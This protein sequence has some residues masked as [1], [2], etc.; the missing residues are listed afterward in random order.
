MA[1]KLYST[2]KDDNISLNHNNYKKLHSSET[3][4]ELLQQ[5][6][7]DLYAD[8]LVNRKT[9]GYEN[10]FN[11]DQLV[12]DLFVIQDE[13]GFDGDYQQHKETI[14]NNCRLLVSPDTT[15]RNFIS[16]NFRQKYIFNND[17]CGLNVLTHLIKNLETEQDYK[18]FIYFAIRDKRR[19]RLLFSQQENLNDLVKGFNPSWNLSQNQ[20][21]NFRTAFIKIMI[22][23]DKQIRNWIGK[24]NRKKIDWDRSSITQAFNIAN[25]EEKVIKTLNFFIRDNKRREKLINSGI[26][27]NALVAET[28]NP[29]ENNIKQVLFPP[30]PAIQV[31]LA[32]SKWQELYTNGFKL[33]SFSLLAN[34]LMNS[35]KSW[36]DNVWRDKE[37]TATLDNGETIRGAGADLALHAY[38]DDLLAAENANVA[39]LENPTVGEMFTCIDN[40]EQQIDQLTQENK[41]LA[42]QKNLSQTEFELAQAQSLETI[43]KQS[44]QIQE[45]QEKLQAIEQK[46]IQLI[47]T[48]KT[49]Q[50]NKSINTENDDLLSSANSNQEKLAKLN[51]DFIQLQ[52]KLQQAT[53]AKTA[54]EESLELTKQ[55]NT[56]LTQ[57]VDNNK[58][59]F[60]QAINTLKQ[61]KS[62]LNQQLTASS[63]QLSQLL[64]SSSKNQLEITNTIEQA[65]QQINQLTL[66]KNS[67]QEKYNNANRLY[68][69]LNQQYN[70]LMTSQSELQASFDTLN[71]ELIQVKN[72]NSELVAEKQLFEE[73]RSQTQ[74][75]SSTLKSELQQTK[76]EYETQINILKKENLAA[77]QAAKLASE[78]LTELNSNIQQIKSQL[79][80]AKDEKNTATLEMQVVLHHIEQLETSNKKLTNEKTQL[81]D[82]IEQLKSE[83][84]QLTNNLNQSEAMRIATFYVSFTKKFVP[85]TP[86]QTLAD[87]NLSES[88]WQDAQNIFGTPSKYRSSSNR[89]NTNTSINEAEN[90]PLQPVTDINTSMNSSSNFSPD[91]NAN[92]NTKLN[93]KLTTRHDIHRLTEAYNSPLQAL[94]ND[95]ISIDSAMNNSPVVPIGH[96]SINTSTNLSQSM[97]AANSP[98]KPVDDRLSILSANNNSPVAPVANHSR[99]SSINMSAQFNAANSPLQPANNNRTSLIEPS[100]TVN[101]PVAQLANVSAGNIS[102][103]VVNSPLQAVSTDRTSIGS[104]HANSPIVALANDIS[105]NKSDMENS[106][107]SETVT[108]S[109]VQALDNNRMSITYA[110][111]NSPLA[112]L[113]NDL[114]SH[115]SPLN[116]STTSNQAMN[117]PL[118]MHENNLSINSPLVDSNQ[119]DSEDDSTRKTRTPSSEF[120]T[121]VVNTPERTSSPSSLSEQVSLTNNHL[122]GELINSPLVENVLNVSTDQEKSHVRRNSASADLLIQSLAPV[123]NGSPKPKQNSNPKVIAFNPVIG[124]IPL[125]TSIT[126][127]ASNNVLT[128]AKQ[129]LFNKNNN[130][131]NANKAKKQTSG[132]NRQAA[133]TVSTMQKS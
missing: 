131:K 33:S 47:S 52:E 100:I 96:T 56:Q 54:A 76:Q 114:S 17:T 57:T 84:T 55:L 87:L 122:E 6:K 8:V 88:E 62:E 30:T 70:L 104:A 128:S 116:N 21:D 115:K 29:A 75:D 112:S 44:N 58:Q 99:N 37:M 101:S 38:H 20:L 65:N 71:Q 3:T 110:A 81:L 50:L 121:D 25:K 11:A 63:D 107:V 32:K 90:S 86:P 40:I 82:Q 132:N 103:E 42:R 102:Q 74:Q 14:V 79:Q 91:I 5:K 111:H 1:N 130:K 24:S 129:S 126:F 83:I 73:E 41:T 72:M 36:F 125:N 7:L 23:D 51:K 120:K 27:E 105:V 49:E 35:F 34:Y 123:L 13:H 2:Y 53:L 4:E 118:Q 59:S 18:N 68:D 60:E 124:P 119:N 113:T 16:K 19:R 64:A 28:V 67:F 46:N 39:R 89:F 106:T 92:N 9:K 80:Q 66:D 43:T 94:V 98:L 77:S 26:I 22:S 95:R 85:T 48:S 127:P 61:E 109:P 108:N 69:E 45:L 10:Y 15:Q 97:I 133:T 117:S 78:K 31:K 12:N 93:N